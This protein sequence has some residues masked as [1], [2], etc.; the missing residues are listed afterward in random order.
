MT[1]SSG[2]VT[3][4]G[5]VSMLEEPD[6]GI[7][8]V[9]LRTINQ[10]VDEFWPEISEQISQIE[11]MFEDPNF[12]DRELAALVASKL[13]FHLEEYTEATRLALGAGSKFDLAEKSEYRS[14][15]ITKVVEFYIDQSREKDQAEVDRRL[16]DF[17]ERLFNHSLKTGSLKSGL[18]I[19]MEARR[20]D[21]VKKFI[22]EAQ[23]AQLVEMLSYC[24]HH[25]RTF[26]NIKSVRSQVLEIMVDG[27]HSAEGEQRDWSG[28][29]QCLYLL[30]RAKEVAGLF[31]EL[32]SNP[33]TRLM[34][35]QL[36]F[37]VADHDDQQ[38]C[39]SVLESIKSDPFPITEKVK[40]VLSGT[41]QIGLNL[42][43]LFR[44]SKTD[45]LLL[46][47]LR[48][49]IDQRS[50]VLHNGVVVSHALMQAGTT[51]DAFLRKNID[52]LAKASHWAKF[53]ASASM[54]VVQKGHLSESRNVLSA[55]LPQV[56]GQS[57]GRSSYSEGGALYALGL[58]HANHHDTATEEYLKSNLD[59][60]QGNEVLQ[61]GACLGLGLT[62][63]ATKSSRVYESLKNVLFLDSAVAGEAAGYAM[64]L[65]MAGSGD[66]AAIRDLLSYAH[67][68]QH[69]KIVRSC[70]V[71][72][73]LVLL[74]Q[75]QNADATIA[76]MVHDTDAIVRY[77]GMFAIGMAY[78]GT[79]QN[80]AVKQLLHFSVSDVS[81]DVRRA[82]V[83]SLGL[84]LSNQPHRLPKVL[85]L[86]S[87]SY[88][89]HV[90][91]GACL[92]LG[93]GCPAMAASVPEAVGLLEP[94]LSDVSEFVRQGAILG[95]SLVCQE[96]SGKQINGKAQQ[97]REKIQ[98]MVGDKHE[99]IMCR[100]GAVLAHG[101]S[102]IGGRNASVPL[103]TKS[104][105]LR[106]GAAVGFC[107][108]AQMWYWYPLM[109]MISLA[110]AP[111]ALIGL[112]KD[113][114]MPKNFSVKSKTKPSTFAYPPEFKPAE[115]KE[116]N[117]VVSAV[118]SAAKKGGKVEEPAP[119]V[120]E[121]EMK[122]EEETPE[123]TEEILDNPCRVV[124]AQEASIHFLSAQDG[125]RYE[126]VI[127]TRTSGYVVLR[128]LKPD[129]P[130]DLLDFGSKPQEAQ[131]GPS[132]EQGQALSLAT[133]QAVTEEEAPPPEAFEWEG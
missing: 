69:E 40:S 28:A 100:F 59:S 29:A 67:E 47:N 104:G 128:D 17:V 14:V 119:E 6:Y 107:L 33:T 60:A 21:W 89:P 76:Q 118:L 68:T 117:R 121:V 98:K 114:R 84:V 65:V 11:S 53:T 86:L 124:H 112:N 108:F 130:E 13:Y 75:E 95:M 66:E 105:S 43:F 106:L 46:E 7:K 91:Y 41:A 132:S 12:P 80:S 32:L 26:V 56:G 61:V 103:F 81:D 102:D 131:P 70:S 5:Y 93:I 48:S 72:L 34:A 64:G 51:N 57:T 36:A 96:T 62:C 55:Y 25:V 97:F 126:P 2:L 15:I 113:V 38:F 92:A 90:R 8:L 115:T 22:Q 52:W 71:G 110:V 10:I 45:L 85:K 19:A 83:I 125:A 44:N 94:L 31:D 88:N 116:V 99:D 4:A 30:G 87:Q 58:I 82:A 63:L 35:L 133:A 127:P 101:L 23:G 122:Q 42:E 120:K 50:S 16:A 24:Q 109:L 27:Y 18:G 3:A 111:T 49:S 129:E 73:A 123:P 1:V 54:G 20:M 77:G 78:C 39:H 37:D 79:S 9:A 74:E